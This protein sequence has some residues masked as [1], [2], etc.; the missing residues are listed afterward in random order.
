[1]KDDGIIQLTTKTKD[2]VEKMAI[3][4][5]EID[6]KEA[7]QLEK[8]SIVRRYNSLVEGC[9][10]LEEHIKFLNAEI[11]LCYQKLENADKQIQ[12]NQKIVQDAL[13]GQN[14]MKDE[15]AKEIGILKNKLHN[16]NAAVSGD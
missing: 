6:E 1:M 10:R 4:R 14:K 13:L 3:S 2:G 5:K 8:D 7:E 12:I 9:M 11:N 15:Y 16:V